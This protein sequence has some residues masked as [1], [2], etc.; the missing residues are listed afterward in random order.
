[1][2]KSYYK[3]SPLAQEHKGKHEYDEVIKVKKMKKT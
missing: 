3:Y 2:L 1:M